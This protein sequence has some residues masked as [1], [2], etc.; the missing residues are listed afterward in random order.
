MN[1]AGFLIEFAIIST[2]F[3]LF[4]GLGYWWGR[5]AESERREHEAAT[6]RAIARGLYEDEGL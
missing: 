4:V 3:C 1:L 2:A 6:K 5:N